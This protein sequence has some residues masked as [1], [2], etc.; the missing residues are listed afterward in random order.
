MIALPTTNAHAITPPRS[1]QTT[2]N[3]MPSKTKIK[4]HLTLHHPPI[5]DPSVTAPPQRLQ[6]PI[7][8]R[9]RRH[10]SS[11]HR[12]SRHRP[13]TRIGQTHR[14]VYKTQ[15]DQV[16]GQFHGEHGNETHA[17]GGAQSVDPGKAVFAEMEEGGFEEDGG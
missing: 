16:L 8:I 2:H 1:E 15:S 7:I 17:A 14:I 11:N 12:Q 5:T 13:E 9:Q 6:P 10:E 3:H 4:V